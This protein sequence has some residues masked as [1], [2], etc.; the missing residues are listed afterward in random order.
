M[1]KC[2]RAV[3][4]RRMAAPLQR[5]DCRQHCGIGAVQPPLIQAHA[6]E[7]VAKIGCAILLVGTQR[8]DALELA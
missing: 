4:V 8:A 2:A 6:V 5:A 1:T 3:V 7:S